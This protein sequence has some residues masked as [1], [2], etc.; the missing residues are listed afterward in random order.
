MTRPTA[1]LI[2]KSSAIHCR[3]WENEAEHI[4]AINRTHSEM[5]KFGPYDPD[6]D[7]VRE[8]VKGLQTGF[9]KTRSFADRQG[10]MYVLKFQRTGFC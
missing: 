2:M 8:R 1:V 7:N 5:V 9:Y 6:Y 10:D 4:C 3:P